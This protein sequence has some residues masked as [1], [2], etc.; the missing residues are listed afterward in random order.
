MLGYDNM[1]IPTRQA[2]LVNG[3]GR[4]KEAVTLSLFN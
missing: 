1:G 4:G 2:C 3:S